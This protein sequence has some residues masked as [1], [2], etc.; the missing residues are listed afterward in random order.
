[1]RIA[2]PLFALCAVLGLCA[3]KAEPLPAAPN[4]DGKYSDANGD[5]TYNIDK[6]GKTDWYTYS[7]FLRYHSECHVC[8]GPDGMGS[9]YAPALKDT[10]KTMS[11]TDFVATVAQ[12]RKNLENGQEKVMPELGL[13]KNVMCYIDDIYTYLKARSANALDRGRPAGHEPKP[14]AWQDAQDGCMGAPS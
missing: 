8:H 1:M 9:T 13:N 12:G 4:A 3:A 6:D 11:Y 5:P 14:K 2:V 10:L 7:G